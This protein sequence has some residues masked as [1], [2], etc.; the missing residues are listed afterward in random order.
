MI[1]APHLKQRSS[2]LVRW[3]LV[4]AA[5]GLTVPI[6][7]A[8]FWTA[9][10]G[11]V[12]ALYVMPLLL[13][14]T[15]GSPRV[16]YV[17]GLAASALVLLGGMTLP[18]ATTPWFA[19]VNRAVSLGVIWASVF[20]RVHSREASLHLEERTR[21]LADV[22]YALEQSAIVAITDTRGTI[23]YVNEK[24]CE[25]SKVLARGAARPRPPDRELGLSPERIHPHALDDDCQR[26]HLAGRNPQPRQRR[27]AVLGGHDNRAVPRRAA[28]ALSIHGHPL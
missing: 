10:I 5:L 8:D 27:F 24:F 22:N 4:A 11:G 9:A 12:G 16:A 17:G 28:K 2:R 20:A 14:T 6:L 1:D 25:I 21:D 13:G 26:A 15:G 23:T 19:L 3:P 18:L 7:A